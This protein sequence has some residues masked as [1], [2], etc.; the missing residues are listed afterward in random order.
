M[1]R[2]RAKRRVYPGE[3]IGDAIR[4]LPENRGGIVELMPGNH[5]TGNAVHVPHGVLLRGWLPRWRRILRA[6]H[7]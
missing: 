1:I 5:Y 4:S 7:L 2:L 3:S 6:L